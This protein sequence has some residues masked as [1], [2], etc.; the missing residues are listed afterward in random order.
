METLRR[1]FAGLPEDQT[2]WLAGARDPEVGRALALLHRQPAHPWII[3]DLAKEV[4]TS[5]SV[6]AE[7]LCRADVDKFE[8]KSWELRVALCLQTIRDVN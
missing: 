7:R 4:G 8:F 5:R 6:V 2:G 1:Y 3:A